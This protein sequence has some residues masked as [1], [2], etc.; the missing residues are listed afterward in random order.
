MA[1]VSWSDGAF[2]NL[3]DRVS[4]GSGY[5]I[6]LVDESGACCPLVWRSNKIK[7]VVKSTIAAEALV[8]GESVGHSLYFAALLEEVL[9]L[10]VKV[11]CLSDSDNLMKALASS[12][13][14][15]DRQLRLDIAAIK[16]VVSEKK[17]SVFHVPGAKMIANCL[18]KRGASSE[19]LLNIYSLV[20]FLKT[21]S[22]FATEAIC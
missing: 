12:H 21:F 4:S 15:E 6:L 9:E 3:P 1:L 10:K 8:F 13:Q 14:V 16:Q 18:T 19:L 11:F 2:A 22:M 17:V 7:R 20:L 5:I